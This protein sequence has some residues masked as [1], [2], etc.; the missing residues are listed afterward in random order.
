MTYVL[1]QVGNENRE[2][3]DVGFLGCVA[4]NDAFHEELEPVEIVHGCQG[5]DD[6]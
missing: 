3:L 2:P 1:Y 5:S 4:I 6:E